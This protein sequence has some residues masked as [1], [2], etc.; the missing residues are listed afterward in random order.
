MLQKNHFKYFKT[1]PEIIKLAVMYYV[2]F[3][4][5]LRQVEDILH[6]RGL[7]VCHETIRF[8]WN[9]FGPIFAKEIRKRRPAAHSLWRWHV[10][11]VFVKING[12]RFYLWRAIDHEGTVLE[13]VV[14]KNRARRSALKTLNKLMKRYGES[15]EIVTDKLG[16]YSAALREI[17]YSRHHETGQYQNNK[18]ENSHLHFRRRE[19]AMCRF[20]SMRSL[21][22]F[23]SIYS[24]FHNHF[25]HQRHLE[26][27]QIF[28]KLRNQSLVDW[29]NIC[30]A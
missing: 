7:D 29:Q 17:G 14:T 3:P 18:C 21:Q 25:Q 27:R 30:A 26:T 15:K 19:R 9:R 8:W 22:K 23:T 10:D 5:S 11:E 28:K 24:Q 16:S 20:R 4:L 2:R 6:E 13:C 12:Q 1:S